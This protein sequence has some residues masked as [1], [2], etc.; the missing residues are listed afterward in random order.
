MERDEVISYVMAHPNTLFHIRTARPIG[1]IEYRE[2]V[3][4]TLTN[5]LTGQTLT[6]FKNVLRKIE[7]IDF[8]ASVPGEYIRPEMKSL[9]VVLQQPHYMEAERNWTNVN[10][11]NILSIEATH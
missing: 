3:P 11:D 4:E 1:V 7:L 5:P 2:N 8:I 9:P 6:F 10:F